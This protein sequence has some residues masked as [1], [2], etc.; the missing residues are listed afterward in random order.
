MISLV[1]GV[2]RSISL[3]KAIVEVGGGRTNSF[4]IS[5]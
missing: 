4:W 3:D 2:V 1:N 5:R